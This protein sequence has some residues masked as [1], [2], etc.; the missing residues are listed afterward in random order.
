MDAEGI[1]KETKT[2]FQTAKKLT[3]QFPKN[4]TGPLKLANDLVDRLQDF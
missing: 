4:V 2:M 1:E 3:F